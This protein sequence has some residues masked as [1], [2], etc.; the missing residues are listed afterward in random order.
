MRLSLN[1]LYGAEIAGISEERYREVLLAAWEALLKER[2]YY[3]Q[4][5]RGEHFVYGLRQVVEKMPEKFRS[6][7]L[8]EHLKYIKRLAAAYPWLVLYEDFVKYK[9]G[10]WERYLIEIEFI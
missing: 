5:R 9:P 8:E 6:M 10:Q 2:G 7:P 3:E 4:W 1:T